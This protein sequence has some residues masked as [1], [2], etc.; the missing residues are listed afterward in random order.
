LLTD[1]QP[2]DFETREAIL[3]KKAETENVPVADDVLAFIAK[4]IPSNIRELEGSLIRVV[5]FASLTK[6]PITVEL[7]AEVLKNAVAA[8]PA[9]RV[10]IPLIKD[11]VAKFYGIS[12]KEMEAQRRDQRVT[13]PRQI[14]MYIAWQLTGASLPQIAREFGKKDHTTAMYA[15]DKIA[16]L[17]DADEAFRNR[18]RS[19]IAIIQSE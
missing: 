12:I 3:R 1:I 10:T 11:R 6:S 9:Q 19:L 13:L 17:M 7:A 2:P 8:S 5:A 15:R 14:A 16:D 4:V 18:V